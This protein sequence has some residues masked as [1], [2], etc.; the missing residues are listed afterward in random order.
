MYIHYICMY[1]CMV[2]G[3]VYL[4]TECR[5]VELQTELTLQETIET[6]ERAWR[7]RKTAYEH[8]MMKVLREKE[9]FGM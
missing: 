1:M 4:F 8:L 2:D 3:N 5:L 7:E 9:S 6:Y